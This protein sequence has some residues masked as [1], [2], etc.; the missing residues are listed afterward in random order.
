MKNLLFVAVALSVFT[1]TPITTKAQP[2]LKFI[3]AVNL[4]PEDSSNISTNYIAPK[5]AKKVTKVAITTKNNIPVET[6][7]CTS[8]QFKY[9]QILNRDVEFVNNLNL[10][11][12]IDDWWATRYRYGGTT[13]RGIDCSSYTGKLL[14]EVYGLN[15]PRTAREQ[16]RVSARVN[17]MD[18]Q[19]GDLVFFN[20]RGGVSHVGIYLGDGFFTHSSSSKGVTINN[21]DESYYS[22]KYI[23]AGRVVSYI[24]EY[25]EEP[26]QE[27]IT[28]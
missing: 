22:K 23:G 17:R 27:I 11:N 2:K 15:V 13:R 16:Y 21:L 28:E 7:L 8:I 3:A 25:V 6:E 18:L 19:E 4:L 12:F 26:E 14:N 1:V 10:Y 9:A 20:T 5:T 24:Q